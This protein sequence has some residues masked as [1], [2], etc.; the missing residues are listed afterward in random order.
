MGV[1]SHEALGFVVAPSVLVITLLPDV[2]NKKSH[3]TQMD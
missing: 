1:H 3:V 2:T